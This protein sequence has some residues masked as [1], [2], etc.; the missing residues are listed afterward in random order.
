[1][2]TFLYRFVEQAVKGLR[3][4]QHD[5]V[6]NAGHQHDLNPMTLRRLLEGYAQHAESHARQLQQI[7]EEYRKAK[8]KK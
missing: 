3:I 4:L 6:P 8:G 5:K 1:M 7:R 2:H